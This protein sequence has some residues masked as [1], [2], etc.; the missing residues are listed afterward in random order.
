[1]EVGLRRPLNIIIVVVIIVII[2][3]STTCWPRAQRLSLSSCQPS[4]PRTFF[5]ARESMALNIER[6]AV[7]L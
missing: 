4:L 5:I 6:R 1:M 7:G 3:I 2:D